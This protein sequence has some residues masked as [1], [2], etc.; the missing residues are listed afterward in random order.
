MGLERTS[1]NKTNQDC[2]G[3]TPLSAT[4]IIDKIPMQ[5]KTYITLSV[6][7]LFVIISISLLVIKISAKRHSENAQRTN[8]S[9]GIAHSQTIDSNQIPNTPLDVAKERD[10]YLRA[11]RECLGLG[12][13][14][15]RE[16]GLSGEQKVSLENLMI[17]YRQALID[18]ISQ[19]GSFKLREDG[20]I[21]IRYSMT[22]SMSQQLQQH[23][24][25][26]MSRITNLPIDKLKASLLFQ[27]CYAD[28]A[29]L[30]EVPILF[31]SDFTSTPTSTQKLV[32]WMTI[33]DKGRLIAR[34]STF[35]PNDFTILFA[36]LVPKINQARLYE[37]KAK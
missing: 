13:E 31:A 9:H 5:K 34:T 3:L 10:I 2:N 8:I 36:P 6:I 16:L 11:Y 35:T 12:L 24:F 4:N 19:Y 23:F 37:S 15:V 7:L 18:D 20:Y 29:Y 22:S 27:T 30:G 25:E 32:T 14:S 17:K 21:E 1:N 28:L 26:E 33:A